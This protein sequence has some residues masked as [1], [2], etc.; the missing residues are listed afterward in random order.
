MIW[1]VFD[2]IQ[3]EHP[4]RSSLGK[5][6]KRARISIYIFTNF[7]HDLKFMKIASCIMHYYIPLFFF[8]FQDEKVLIVIGGDENYRDNDEENGSTLSRQARDTALSRQLRPQ[9]IDGRKSFIFSWNKKHRAIHEEAL[10]HYFDCTKKG[11]KF[12]SQPVAESV[13]IG[14]EPEETRITSPVATQSQVIM[15]CSI[16]DLRIPRSNA[17]Q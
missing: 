5:V 13:R 17:V 7:N 3:K 4:L 12:T 11:Q 2:I 8:S 1:A 10:I 15:T 9:L 16:S 14:P 6:V